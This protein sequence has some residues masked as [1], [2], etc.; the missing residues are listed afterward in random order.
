M[1]FRPLHE[2]IDHMEEEF[3][4]FKL[5]DSFEEKKRAWRNYLGASTRF[6]NHG[7]KLSKNFGGSFSG[8]WGLQKHKRKKDELLIYLQHARNCGDHSIE[9]VLEHSDRGSTGIGVGGGTAYFE[10]LV[11]E[12]GV[13]KKMKATMSEGM[14][15]IQVRPAGAT[16]K[17]VIDG[18]QE[19]SPPNFADGKGIIVQSPERIMELGVELHKLIL[20]D[21]EDQFLD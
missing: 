11:I 10:E 4:R 13:I 18:N 12:N 19:Y 16:L 2:I 15:P 7:S 6:W 21:A 17:T 9:E 5:V 20:C 14:I 3:N 8:W 1:H